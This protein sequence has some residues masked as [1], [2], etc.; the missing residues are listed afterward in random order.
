MLGHVLHLDRVPQVRLV[1]AVLGHRLVVGDA[2]E[3]GRDGL[4]LGELLEHALDHRLHRGENVVL[5]D[6][7]HL[8][9]ELVELT[10]Q[11]VGARVLVAETRRDLEIAVEA[12]DHD[13]LLVLLRRLRQ[14]VELALVDPARHQEVAR[15]FRARGGQDGR[16]ELEEAGCLHAGA[17]RLDDRKTAHDVGVQRLAAQIEEAVLQAQVFR[18]IGLGEDRHGQFAG[19]REHFYLGCEQL[20]GAGRQFVVPRSLGP[21]AHLAI[22]ADDPFGTHLLGHRECR[23]VGVGD[24]LGQPIVVA[25]VDEQHPAMVADAMDPPGQA[26][27]VA[28]I[29]LAQRRTGVGAVAVE[30]GLSHGRGFPSD[31]LRSQAC[32][33]ARRGGEK[34]MHWR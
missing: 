31:R 25:Q 11:A 22:D 10:G 3:D 28:D 8:D 9:V 30:G 23:A 2:R 27:V 33:M 18:V 7:A 19:F 16:C 20:D 1:G 34:R 26:H 5:L 6:E 4:A 32:R 12:R 14:R 29:G 24:D 17:D 13:E 21:F 15:A